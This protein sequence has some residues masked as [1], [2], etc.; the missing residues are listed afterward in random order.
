[1]E[2][3]KKVEKRSAPKKAAKRKSHSSEPYLKLADAIMHPE[4]REKPVKRKSTV[5]K[6]TKSELAEE[7]KQQK[8]PVLRGVKFEARYPER[9]PEKPPEPEA[10]K[11]EI[12][13]RNVYYGGQH[14]PALCFRKPGAMH[15][16]CVCGD[17]IEGVRKFTI[18]S[19]QHDKS[20]IVQHGF[21]AFAAPYSPERFARHMRTLAA[22]APVTPEAR[23]MLLPF[24]P[25]MPSGPAALPGSLTAPDAAPDDEAQPV[26]RRIASG[27]RPKAPAGPSRTDGKE[28]IKR[29]GAAYGLPPEKIRA[30]LRAAG[31][32]APYTDE[33]A[34]VAKLGK[35]KQ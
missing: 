23:T 35:P 8:A 18:P 34:C 22:A 25:D 30:K 21:G 31:L 3:R 13:V 4:G 7:S 5:V 11:Q 19:S 15:V 20:P 24:V 10:P 29:L 6:M 32:R 12:S 17:P 9:I 33:A 16:P 27:T 14:L 2:K 26:A 1:M 28:L